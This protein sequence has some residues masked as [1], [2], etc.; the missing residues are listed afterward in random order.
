MAVEE[1]GEVAHTYS[2]NILEAE[3][4]GLSCIWGPRLQSETLSQSNN[5]NNNKSLYGLNE[6]EIYNKNYFCT[7]P[8]GQKF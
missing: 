1:Q 2:P 5:N 7:C 6:I 8:S 4:G 3:S